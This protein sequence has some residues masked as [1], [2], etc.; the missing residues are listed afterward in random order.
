MNVAPMH[1]FPCPH[2]GLRDETE[3]RFGAEAGKRRPEPV[4]EVTA[5]AWA[6]YLYISNA[7]MGMARE[8]WVHLTCGEFF[9]M[10][11]DTQTHAV[12]TA[13]ALRNLPP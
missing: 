8:V 2:C 3:F 7:P 9:L 13:L 11:R 10:D 1:Q 5:E 4:A 12:T 6:E